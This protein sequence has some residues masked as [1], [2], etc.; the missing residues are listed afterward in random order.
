MTERSV[1][2]EIRRNCLGA[3]QPCFR[4]FVAF[5]KVLWGVFW[6]LIHFKLEMND[7][8]AQIGDS[9]FRACYAACFRDLTLFSDLY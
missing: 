6:L 3:F 5:C 9:L 1:M 2:S 7:C 8:G 4:K